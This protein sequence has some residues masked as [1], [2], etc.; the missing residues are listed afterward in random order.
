MQDARPL[1]AHILGTRF[2]TRKAGAID[3]A[4]V[5]PRLRAMPR[6]RASGGA[7]TNNEDLYVCHDIHERITRRSA[8]WF[9][10]G[11]GAQKHP[12]RITRA[13]G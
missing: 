3:Q 9:A 11:G 6:G 12:E 13:E 2:G 5:E 8:K 10:S 7:T 1:R 4:H